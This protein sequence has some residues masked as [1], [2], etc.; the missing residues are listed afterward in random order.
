MNNLRNILI[1]FLINV[2]VL[3]LIILFFGGDLIHFLVDKK[4][5]LLALFPTFIGQALGYL[6]FITSEESKRKRKT[7]IIVS[8]ICTIFFGSLIFYLKFSEWNHQNN[9]GNIESNADYFKYFISNHKK[10]K[11]IAF[12]TLSKKFKNAN[13]FRLSGSSL[14]SFDTTL[15]NQREQIFLID[16]IYSK[17]NK[18]GEFQAELIVFKEMAKLFFFDKILDKNDRSKTDSLHK[19]AINNINKSLQEVPE[20]I[21]N[22]IQ[23][24]FKEVL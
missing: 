3:S 21:R 23:K 1:F 5:W 10:E 2:A 24:E 9:Y 16:F 7:I 8:A 15:N 17:K 4:L 19:K 11:Q 20:S 18:E 22:E 6:V 13:E 12:D 14:S